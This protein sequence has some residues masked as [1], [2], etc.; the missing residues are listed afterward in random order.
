MCLKEQLL[1]LSA[2]ISWTVCT[3]GSILMAKME[4]HLPQQ[5]LFSVLAT[6]GVAAMHFTGMAATTF[7]SKEP[8]SNQPNKLS[9]PRYKLAFTTL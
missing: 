7:W 4:T 3:V 6:A 8:A 9:C 1:I 5:I 2:L